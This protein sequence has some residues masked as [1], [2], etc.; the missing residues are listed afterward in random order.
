MT[1]PTSEALIALIIQRIRAEF[2][3]NPRIFTKVQLAIKSEIAVKDAIQNLMNEGTFP[4]GDIK[5]S[6]KSHQFPDIVV[7]LDDYLLGIEV[8]SSSSSSNKSWSIN[9]NSVVGSTSIKTDDTYIVF[10]KYNEIHGFDIKSARYEDC[11]ANVGVTHSPRYMIDLNI[12]PSESFFKKSGI[13]YEK[14]KNSDSP[15]SLIT[16][17]FRAQGKIAWWLGDYKNENSTSATI[18]SWDDLNHSQID[19]IYGQAFILFP[20]IFG[21]LRTN[22]YKRLSQWLIAKHSVLISSLR[23]KFSAGGTV[24][25]ACGSLIIDPAP[26]IYS[27]LTKNKINID[28]AFIDLELIELNTFWLDYNPIKDDTETRKYYWSSMLKNHINDQELV[29]YIN[30]LFEINI[31]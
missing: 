21:R 20:E 23:D 19:K 31:P 2:K 18:L 16:D 7:S 17:H 1:Y 30:L 12:D 29:N 26:H 27:V 11:V 9:G 14:I 22:K 28:L 3:N 6:E 5:Y 24:K 15:I 8:K 13:G 25:L 4:E 10:I